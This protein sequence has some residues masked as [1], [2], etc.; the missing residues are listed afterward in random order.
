MLDYHPIESFEDDT[1]NYGYGI[2][3][4]LIGGLVI[5]LIVM[6]TAKSE[7]KRGAVHA[8]CAKMV[9]GFLVYGFI[10]MGSG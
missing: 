10:L 7:T 9:L 8:F 3:W 2:F 5:F 6:S 1:G 4:G